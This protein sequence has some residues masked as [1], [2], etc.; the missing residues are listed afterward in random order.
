MNDP[1]PNLQ[2]SPL[3]LGQ[4]NLSSQNKSCFLLRVTFFRCYYL[5]ISYISKIKDDL[6]ILHCSIGPWGSSSITFCVCYKRCPC[7]PN[8]AIQKTT[9]NKR[10]M[11]HL[12]WCWI[13]ISDCWFMCTD[14]SNNS[15]WHIP[16]L[17]KTLLKQMT[18]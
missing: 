12:L 9:T 5:I 14:F 1:D 13:P 15:Y 6:T 11:L 7:L 10:I 2:T 8:R 16:L 4:V 18:W 3:F 17:Q